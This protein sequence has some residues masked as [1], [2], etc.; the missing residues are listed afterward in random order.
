MGKKTSKIWKWFI[1]TNQSFPHSI[2]SNTNQL[3]CIL[4]G[5]EVKQT[6]S[7]GINHLRYK[8]PDIYKKITKKTAKIREECIY[9][10]TTVLKCN[11]KR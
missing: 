8:H 1:N 9:C 10:F 11:L 5:K 7:S 2:Q 3:I 6:S 4:C